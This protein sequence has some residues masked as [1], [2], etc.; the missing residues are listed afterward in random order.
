MSATSACVS[1]RFTLAG[2][3][4]TSDF[5]GTFTTGADARVLTGDRDL[6]GRADLYSIDGGGAMHPFGLRRVGIEL[7]RVHDADAV[8]S[9]VGVFVLRHRDVGFETRGGRLSVSSCG[10]LV[11]PASVR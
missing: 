2:L 10:G 9:P 5:A 6:D 4:I 7:V 3:P 1:R 11:R 8:V